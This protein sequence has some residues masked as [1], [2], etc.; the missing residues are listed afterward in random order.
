MEKEKENENVENV[1]L[2][3]SSTVIESVNETECGPEGCGK[4]VRRPENEK[5]EKALRDSVY[6]SMGIGI[7]P[8]TFVNVAA[9]TASNLNLVRKL[10]ELYGVEFKESMAKKIIISITGASAGVLA[11]PIIEMA[12]IGLP[13]VGLPL[14]VGTQP[15]LNGMTTYALGRMF[16]T[17]FER[18]GSFI[19]ANTDTMKE[20]FSEAY[21]NSRQ[22]LGKT[23]SGEKNVE[24]SNA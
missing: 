6:A 7:I 3:Q 2:E 22:W 9:V 14:A 15:I 13:L 12:V 5:V 8:L 18:G 11:S 10:S 16:V 4:A 17:H 23:I 21:K 19:G 24:P 1:K 20:D